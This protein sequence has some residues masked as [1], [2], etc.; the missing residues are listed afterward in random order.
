MAA[1]PVNCKSTSNDLTIDVSSSDDDDS[2]TELQLK[3]F[4]EVID[5][6]NDLMP[7]DR[8]YHISNSAGLLKSSSNFF[9]ASSTCIDF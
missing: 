2:F 9:I 6:A 4:K 3:I 7:E 5:I 8:D 1:S